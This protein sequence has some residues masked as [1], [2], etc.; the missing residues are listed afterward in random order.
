[1]TSTKYI[2]Y[3]DLGI[4]D[5]GL[6]RFAVDGSATSRLGVTGHPQRCFR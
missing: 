2:G 6:N 3:A 4:A 5:I 1:M